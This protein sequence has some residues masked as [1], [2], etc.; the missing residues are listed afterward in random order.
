MFFYFADSLQSMSRHRPE[1]QTG[2]KGDKSCKNKWPK[3]EA[4]KTAW[5]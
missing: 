5:I 1:I 2:P 3:K 4:K